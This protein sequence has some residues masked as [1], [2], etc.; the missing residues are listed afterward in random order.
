MQT[1]AEAGGDVAAADRLAEQEVVGAA[2]VGVI[3][4]DGAVLA[5]GNDSRCVV[6]PLERDRREQDRIGVRRGAGV[7]IRQAVEQL[8]RVG[9]TDPRQHV[10]IESENADEL[11]DLVGRQALIDAGGIERVIE[12]KTASDG[13]RG[14]VIRW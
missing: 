4:A 6:T 14:G 11:V 2:T 13:A 5:S 8:H 3:V 9:R 12:A 10:D 1:H 7:G